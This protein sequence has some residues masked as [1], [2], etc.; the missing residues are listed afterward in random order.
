MR[1]VGLR[2]T[3][4]F[5]LA[6]H[7]PSVRPQ[8]VSLIEDKRRLRDQ[9][10]VLRAAWARDVVDAAAAAR[11]Q[12]T[13]FVETL[14]AELARSPAPTISGYW[15]M[16]DE[17]D[18]RPLMT[19]LFERGHVLALPV[20]V[21]R[22]EALVFRRWQPGDRLVEAGFG[23]R[24]PGEKAAEAVPD[25]VLAPLLA[26]DDAGRRLGY[27]GGYYDRTLR[28]LRSAGRV[29]AV[30]VGYQAQRVDEV[31]SGDGDEKLDWIVTEERAIRCR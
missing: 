10:R 21:A 14:A 20:V 3:A 24:E 16:A 29:V 9:A 22:G 18:V 31:P 12:C 11:R 8:T 28:A 1:P 23:T 26:F 27:G 15:P 30:G 25:L 13:L 6:G 7:R 17:F 5:H 4:Y 19:R 2:G